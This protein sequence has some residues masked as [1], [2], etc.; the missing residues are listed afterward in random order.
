[1]PH[2]EA[3]MSS[4]G[5]LTVPAPVRNFFKLKTGDIVDFYLDEA[6]RSVRLRA[7]N[8]PISELIGSLNAY[9]EPGAPSLT[10]A[11]IDAAVAEHLAEEDSRIMREHSEW[12]AF[13]EWRRK[14]RD[15]AAE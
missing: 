1:M 10:P 15:Q 8:M 3:K 5:Q 12:R 6:S 2:F 14:H 13:Q 9:V 11:A 7:R 4:K